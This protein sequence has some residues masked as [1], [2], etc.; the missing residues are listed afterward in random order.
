MHPTAEVDE[1]A[2]VG[3]GTRIWRDVQVRQG[4]VIG[5]DCILGKGTYVDVEVT[6]GNRC[7]LENGVQAF[8]G[9]VVADGVFLGPGALLLNDKNPRAV[10]ADGTVK[11][12]DDWHL[13]GVQVGTGASIGAGAV[14]LPGVRIGRFAMV[15]SGA[16]VTRDVP[17]QAV[18]AGNPARLRGYV[19]VCGAPFAEPPREGRATCGSC[20]R[21]ARIGP[22][23]Q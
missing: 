6:I 9:A 7:K 20:H 2:T 22:A 21:E 14:V 19:C 12:A 15:G 23:G 11:S 18:V 10:N 16:V 17:D 13:S 5:E 3:R 1:G 4:A 8:R